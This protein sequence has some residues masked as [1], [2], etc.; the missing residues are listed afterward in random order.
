MRDQ[1]VRRLAGNTV[2]SEQLPAVEI[3]VTETLAFVG[4]LRFTLSEVAE[5]QAFVFVAG[6]VPEV[7]QVLIVQFEGYLP[8]RGGTY[9]YP[10]PRRI[11]LG[12]HP[13]QSDTALLSLT[14]P[15]P[16]ES[17]VGR[18]LA[19]LEE[20]GY[21]LPAAAI[22]QRFVRVLGEARRDELLIFGIE[23]LDDA[24]LIADLARAG[25][26]IPAPPALAQAAEERALARFT[27]VDVDVD[28]ASGR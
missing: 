3:T 25:R 28:V 2:V 13:Y 15:P 10:S 27:L 12:R 18:I 6:R 1:R 19:L 21:A 8:G 26:P 22:S 16:P 23:P 4:E 7:G 11:T 24:A 20:R 17:N 5:A 14:P 9:T